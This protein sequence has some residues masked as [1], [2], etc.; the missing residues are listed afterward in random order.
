MP[1]GWISYSLESV[2]ISGTQGISIG[3]IQVPN[4]IK[5]AWLLHCDSHV[6][7]GHSSCQLL[8]Y[9][10][11]PVTFDFLKQIYSTYL[12][13]DI[14]QQIGILKTAMRHIQMISTISA[15]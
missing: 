2:G 13:N 3:I 4:S 12:K 14:V 9:L 15:L 6:L 5:S 7:A 1:A 10:E 11:S 8:M